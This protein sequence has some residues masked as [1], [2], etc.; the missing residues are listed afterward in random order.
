M[1]ALFEF[2][3]HSRQ[4]KLLVSSQDGAF[5][6]NNPDCAMDAQKML[7]QP[8]DNICSIQ[9]RNCETETLRVFRLITGQVFGKL[10]E[11]SQSEDD[12]A[13]AAAAAAGGEEWQ[14][15]YLKEHMVGILFSRSKL[16]H[17]QRQV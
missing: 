13:G 3:S 1:L 9:Q 2:F 12:P 11:E 10:L 5:D 6:H 8:Q 7:V 17:L 14:E 4:V 16:T 15:N